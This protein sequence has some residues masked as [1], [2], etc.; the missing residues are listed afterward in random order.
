MGRKTK[1]EE[2]GGFIQGQCPLVAAVVLNEQLSINFLLL[3][4]QEEDKAYQAVME[5][6]PAALSVN[7]IKLSAKIFINEK[8]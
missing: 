1:T 3:N 7:I 4:Y 2:M 5:A 6:Y 8:K